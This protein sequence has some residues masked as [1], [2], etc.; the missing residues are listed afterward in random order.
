MKSESRSELNLAVIPGDGIGVEV[1]TCALEVL[2]AAAEAFDGPALRTTTFHWG[3]EYYLES[4]RMIA[5]DALESLERF[6]AVLFGAV[7]SPAVPDHVSLWGL[8]LAI[9]QGFDQGVNVRPVRLLPGVISP[10]AGRDADDIDFVVIRENSEGEYAGVGGRSHR[11]TPAEVAVQTAVYSRAA[12]ERVGRY[13]F[14][15]AASRPARHLI[16]VTKS[17]AMQYTSVLWDE[18]LAELAREH[19]GVRFES[20]LVDAMA[21]RLV[22]R[23]DSVDV[24]VASNLH[25]DILSDLTSAL[26]GSLGVA[27]SANLNVEGRYPSM[28]EPIHGTAPDIAGQGIANP[29]G[30][31]LTVAML[32]EHVAQTGVAEAIREAVRK[33]CASGP[34]TPDL[35]GDGTSRSLTAAIIRALGQAEL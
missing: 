7:G 24:L 5:E 17:N 3:S 4:G 26:A 29:I 32:A 1:T 22:L 15:V 23:P 6:D 25:A 28:F 33:A 21:A 10:L 27:P 9:C 18:I 35:G 20:E 31:I 16:S 34:L 8:R 14:L 19:P 2:E 30:A 11:G 13:A 12:I